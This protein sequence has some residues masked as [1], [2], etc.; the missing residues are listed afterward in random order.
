MTSEESR[1]DRALRPDLGQALSRSYPQQTIDVGVTLFLLLLGMGWL[2]LSMKVLPFSDYPNHLARFF[3]QSQVGSDEFLARYYQPFWR[4]Q[5]NL[6]LD[7]PAYVLTPFL[8]IFR[9]GRLTVWA[10]FASLAVGCVALHRVIHHRFSIIS[11]VPMLL[12]VN[13]YFISGFLAFLLSLGWALIGFALWIACRERP[14]LR[15]ALGTVVATGVYLGH[16]YAF[17]I[18]GVCIVGYELFLIQSSLERKHFLARMAIALA[19]FLPSIFLFLFVSP[20]VGSY[21]MTEWRPL[22]DKL[23]GI[24]VLFPGYDLWLEVPLL[25]AA[26]LVLLV[27]WFRGAAILRRDFLV[28]I[29]IFVVLYLAMPDILF[30]SY[31]ADRRILVPIA[32]LALLSFDWKAQSMKVRALQ[33]ALPIGIL[34]AQ[35]VHVGIEWRSSQPL[36]QEI[37]RL[38][39][40]VEMGA[41]IAGATV[42]RTEQYL[43]FP[44]LHEV[45]SLFVIERSAFVPNLYAYPQE[46]AT[47]LRYTPDYAARAFRPPVIYAPDHGGGGND[48]QSK[49]DRYLQIAEAN[50]ID[51]L[52]L[53]DEP[54]S[55]LRL[56]ANYQLIGQTTGGKAR[57]FRIAH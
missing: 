43:N 36:Y 48:A 22:A 13:R 41:H 47:P 38:T 54:P 17:G 14:L 31:G 20:T 25:A 52:L 57:L 4:F 45:V 28:A 27:A 9:V 50:A 53:I 7:A 29:A 40:K 26:C 35:L 34:A 6:A 3:I 56:P 44:P 19:P 16:L 46:S 1:F 30:T 32:L 49:L 33:A 37:F 51:Y 42:I 39:E 11:L 12:I 18:Y 8:D 23:A 24:V 2:C 55:A 10:T 15:F 21:H 5:P